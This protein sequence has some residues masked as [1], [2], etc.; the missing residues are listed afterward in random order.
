MKNSIRQMLRTPFKLLLFFLFLGASAVLL[1]LGLRLWLETGEKI[2]QAEETFT[3]IGMVRQKE[4]LME[5]V[6][7]GRRK[8]LWKPFLHGMLEQRVIHI[9]IILFMKRSFRRVYWILTMQVIWQDRRN[10]QFT[11]PGCRILL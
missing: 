4:N 11:V 7:S 2:R 1:T 5:A 8:I 10:G 3:T 9:L 6:W